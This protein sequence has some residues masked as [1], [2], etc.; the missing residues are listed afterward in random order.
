MRRSNRREFLKASTGMLGLAY[1]G[2]PRPR[3]GTKPLLSFSTL[4]C[5]GW[6]YSAI[7]DFAQDH[8]YDGIEI[9]GIL[10]QLELPQCPEFIDKQHIV[11]SLQMAKNKNLR[12]VDLGSSAEL[13]HLDPVK[14]QA[15][16][17]EA[18][19]FIDLAAALECPFV[20]VFP[21]QL[22]KNEQRQATVDAI[23][24]N[25]A[26]LGRYANGG[27]VSVLMESHGDAVLT[28]ELRHI[29][30]SAAGP[31]TGMVWDV[32][33]MWSVTKES[34]ADV[35]RQLK[36]YIRHTHI[37]DAKLVDGKERY[38]LLGRGESPIFEAIDLLVAG[39]YDGYYSFEWEKLW[40]PEIDAPELA[41]ADYPLAMKKHF[42]SKQ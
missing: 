5:P 18:K 33:N 35:Y 32:Y 39:G 34:P 15:N 38:V 10:G 13:H 16:L 9:R 24:A 19:R 4:G 8:G 12:F 21:N 27:P 29:M 23:I 26:E 36:P 40:H 6:T 25:L 20:R 2:Y 22:P 28:P 42:Q 41:L 7:L 14:R 1:A 11:Q 31:H 37:K 30:E 3:A 17:D